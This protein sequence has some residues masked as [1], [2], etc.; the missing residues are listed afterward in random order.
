MADDPW[1]AGTL[2][3]Y[4]PT[5]LRNEHGAGILWITSDLDE[6]EDVADRIVVLAAG[7][8]VATLPRGVDRATI[9]RALA[10]GAP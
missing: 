4:F 3:D 1:F 2:A 6:A 9:G 10:G 7:R 5:R 8:V